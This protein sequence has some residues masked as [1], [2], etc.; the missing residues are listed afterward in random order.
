MGIEI[1][2]L[3]K[4]CSGRKLS[5]Y[6]KDNDCSRVDVRSALENIWILVTAGKA[7]GCNVM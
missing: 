3:Y 6:L 2:W 5:F 7:V 4:F 1:T